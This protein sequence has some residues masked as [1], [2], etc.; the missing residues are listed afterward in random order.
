[1]INKFSVNIRVYL[2]F[3]TFNKVKLSGRSDIPRSGPAICWAGGNTLA[4][5]TGELGVRCWDLHTGDTYVLS[6][7]DSLTGNLA[8]PQEI[9]TSLSFCKNNGICYTL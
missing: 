5:L 8:T 3:Y 6:P 2:L 1:M 9:C 4:V 7:P